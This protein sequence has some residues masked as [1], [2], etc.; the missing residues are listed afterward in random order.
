MKFLLVIQGDEAAQAKAT[1]AD[2]ERV[3]TAY[4]EYTEAMNRA[5]VRLGGE[6]LMP[7]ARASKVQMR[8]GKSSV[9]DGP[10]TEAR[11]VV[12]GYYLIDV[13]TREEAISWGERCPGA[14]FGTIEV[15][16]VV[17]MEYNQAM[18]HG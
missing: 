11:E 3:F 4:R 9:V 10:F 15:R 6:A 17:S 7:S 18:S 1:P 16:E 12:G 8:G 13:P 5:G 14:H 2:R